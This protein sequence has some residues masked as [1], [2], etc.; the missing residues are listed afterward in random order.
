M[1]DFSLC[2]RIWSLKGDTAYQNAFM[3]TY[4]KEHY[5]LTTSFVSKPTVAECLEL[6]LIRKYG[7]P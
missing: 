1:P 5:A 3:K 6:Q 7:Q 4:S 2:F